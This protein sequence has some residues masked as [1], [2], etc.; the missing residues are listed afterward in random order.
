M[1]ILS[2]RAQQSIVIDDHIN[3]TVLGV[4]NGQVRLGIEAP[5]SVNIVREELLDAVSDENHHALAGGVSLDNLPDIPAA[6]A[7]KK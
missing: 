3:V 2:R 5:R 1:L 6:V 4:E 7:V